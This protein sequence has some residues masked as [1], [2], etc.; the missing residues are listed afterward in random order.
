MLA[1][2]AGASV[3]R[4]EQ[5]DRVVTLT[6]IIEEQHQFADV[7][8]GVVQHRSIDLHVACI[9]RA[10]CRVSVF[11]RRYARIRCRQMGAGGHKAH[12]LLAGQAL[13]AR[14]APTTVVFP[15]IT[16]DVLGFG[17]QRRMHCIV[18]HIQE[19]RF[20]GAAGAQLLYESDALIHPIVAAVVAR[21]IGIDRK[22]LVVLHEACRKEVMHLACH[23]SVKR[24]EAT[25]R[26]PVV[27]RSTG[28]RVG[29]RRVVPLAHHD[30]FVTGC[31]K[32][33]GQRSRIQRDFA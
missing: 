27:L 23:E 11:P 21:R 13:G 2:I 4:G 32:R 22:Q 8:I 7:L 31:P 29:H 17:M 1:A 12:G 14:H 25:L 9:Q 24:I 6:Q 10:V 5:D 19:E 30:G 15:A 28:N 18:R 20:G 26:G 16:R 33:F 3:I